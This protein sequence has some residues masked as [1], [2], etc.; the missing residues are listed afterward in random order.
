MSRAIYAISK[1]LLF[2][3]AK[4]FF[5]LEAHGT[6]HVPSDG[7]YLLICN[8]ASYI[9]PPLVGVKI[10]RQ[11]HFLAKKELF[12]VPLLGRWISMVGGHAVDRGKGDRKAVVE[13][14]R[15]LKSGKMLVAFP[16]GTR[17]PDGNLQP[18]KP[19]IVMIVQ[20]AGVPCVPAYVDG[21]FVA[22]PRHRAF[23]VPTKV[24][25]F[26]GPPFPMPER[27]PDMTKKAYYQHCLD[28]MMEHITALKKQAEQRFPKG[29]VDGKEKV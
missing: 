16:E 13:S 2:V 6:E 8:H 10:P 17:T 14:L 1:F 7:G 3:M 20:Q 9:D 19:G 4:L 18:G 26:Y 24:R 25:V 28:T 27:N 21:S 15:V 22:W 12:Q 11:L 23:P 5:R 29:A